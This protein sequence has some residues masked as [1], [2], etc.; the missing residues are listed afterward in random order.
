[1]K[2]KD[3]AE[4]V[5]LIRKEDSRY[6]K[7]AYY[8]LRQA[9]DHTVKKLRDDNRAERQHVTG[10]QLLDGIREYA[11]EQYGPMAFTLLTEWGVESCEDFGNIVFN[12]VD[13]EILGKT[14]NDKPEDFS[15][16]YNFREAF[17]EPFEPKSNWRGPRVRIPVDG[18]DAITRN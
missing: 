5:Q 11:L 15:A 18:E 9:L 7:G 14:E 16:V 10:P 8:F 12:L 2:H 6:E 4:V 17:A 1:M 3:F 13:Y